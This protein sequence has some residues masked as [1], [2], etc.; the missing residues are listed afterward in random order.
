M[1]NSNTV[2]ATTAARNSSSRETFVALPTFQRE[3]RACC[4]GSTAFA[5]VANPV[6]EQLEPVATAF[7]PVFGNLEELAPDLRDFV[8]DLGPTISASSRACPRRAPS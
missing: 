7:G 6:I 3:S 2:F 5:D 1:R 4:G 8:V